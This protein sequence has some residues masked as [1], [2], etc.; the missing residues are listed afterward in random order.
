MLNAFVG[1]YKRLWSEHEFL[2]IVLLA[3]AF[4]AIVFG[5][6]YY[7]AGLSGGVLACTSGSLLF[8]SLG[9]IFLIF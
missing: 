9:A 8:N 7:F 6:G 3:V 4:T 2:V 1:W 5:V